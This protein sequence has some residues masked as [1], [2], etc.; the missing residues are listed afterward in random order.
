M[1]KTA[2]DGAC[3]KIINH[4]REKEKERNLPELREAWANVRPVKKI[5]VLK[6]GGGISAKGEGK[7]GTHPRARDTRGAPKAHSLKTVAGSFYV[8]GKR[9]GRSKGT[10]STC[11]GINKKLWVQ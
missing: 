3:R 7:K 2:F 8:L 9:G 11:R 5:P 1:F 6:K 10:V 4:V